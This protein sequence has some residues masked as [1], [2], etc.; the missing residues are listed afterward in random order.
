MTKNKNV[1]YGLLKKYPNYK[2][3]EHYKLRCSSQEEGVII[4]EW[5]APEPKP[6][7]DEMHL[8]GF[9]YLEEL[10]IKKQEKRNAKLSLISKLSNL[11]LLPNEIEILLE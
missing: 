3:G 11:G 2:S 4:Y 9:Q 6:N 7:E 10:E 8:L 1:Y 5:N